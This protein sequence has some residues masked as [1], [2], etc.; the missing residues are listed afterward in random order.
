MEV[1]EFTDMIGCMMRVSWAAS[2]G[3]HH[4][5]SSIQPA[6]DNA[7]GRLRQNSAGMSLTAYI[8]WSV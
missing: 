1:L 6:R 4:L 2:V 8:Q 3:K 5:S 7:Y